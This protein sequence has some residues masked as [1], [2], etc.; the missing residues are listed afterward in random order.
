MDELPTKG[1]TGVT[2]ADL[3]WLTGSWLGRNGEDPVEEHWSP[4][5]GNTLMGMFRWVSDG[6]VRFYELTAIEQEGEFVF[7]R[8]KHFDPGL[9]GWEEKDRAHQ[10]LLVRLQGTEALFLE[11]ERPDARW[12]VYRREGDDR[13]VSYFTRENEPVTET[14]MFEYARQ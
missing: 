4:L 9:V 14:G 2:P 5:R 8:I 3:A 6:K 10:F 7:F 12:A 1:L 11:L 13:L